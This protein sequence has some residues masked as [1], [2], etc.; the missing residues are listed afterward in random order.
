[1]RSAFAGPLDDD[2][3]DHIIHAVR[4]NP[5]ALLQL[6]GELTPSQL[7]GDSLLPDPLPHFKH[8]EESFLRR[9]RR[10]PSETQ[11]M[12]LLIAADPTLERDLLSRASLDMD[13]GP[14]ALD[15]AETDGLITIGAQV[16]FRHP[17]LRSAIYDGAD[18]AQR[19]DAHHLLATLMD[20][21]LDPDRK[22]WHDGGAAIGPDAAVAA[23]LEHSAER[24]S[25]RGGYAAAAAFLERSVQ[26]TF[27]P[28]IRRGRAL[29]AAEAE[30]TAGAASRAS[31]TLDEVGAEL[32]DP[33]HIAL[34]QRLR[35]VVDLELANG[36]DSAETLL[37]AAQAL[38]PLD[39]RLARD[40]YLE[41]LMAAVYA[42]FLGRRGAVLDA[43][44]KAQAA[45][46]S[47]SSKVMSGDLLLDGFASLII[48][49]PGSAVPT[50][51]RALEQLRDDG[52]L[53]WLGL[54]SIAATELWDDEALHALDTT[55]VRLARDSGALMALP[56]ALQLL[57]IF[58]IHAGRFDTAE[59]CLDEAREIR[60][61]TG[62]PGMI[63]RGNVGRLLLSAWR[64]VP[65]T[66][67]FADVTARDANARG[68][69]IGVDHAHYA[70]ALFELGRCQYDAALVA[71]RAAVAHD[72]IY[73]VPMALPELVEAAARSGNTDEAAA[74]AERLAAMAVA[75]STEWGLGVLAQARALSAEDENAEEL[76]LEALDRLGRCRVV[77]GLGR[78]RLVYGEWLR[79]KRRRADAREQLLAAHQLFSEIG[80][81]GFAERAR[82]ELSAIGGRTPERL[83]E[84]STDV[85]TP[86]EWRIA[87]L[88]ADGA[89]NPEIAAQLFISVRTVE[90]HLHK[91]FRKLEVRSRTE[92]AVDVRLRSE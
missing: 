46:R 42:G 13:I 84:S 35:V 3:R 19:R 69:G 63:D 11:S 62:T 89:S 6:A 26:L 83:A 71:G 12:L 65:E 17:L 8:L 24:A 81:D 10:L 38:E 56:R 31:V 49:G 4:G 36:R 29:A 23:E 16:T 54:G 45:P 48:D 59:A 51:R 75:S 27:E 68:Q 28:E 87:R 44:K 2:V 60:A 76:Y 77:T 85:L 58:E 67:A 39:V 18:P 52:D 66:P 91:I 92:L 9:V 15:A 90:Y 34:A 14:G 5:L 30:L 22:A 50:L 88:V 1:L 55:R 61:A 32:T 79:R 53:A 57:A 74:A 37:A 73:V 40:T 41:A 47:S 78:A 64:G 72:S 21:E 43:A 7:S 25:A 80:A 70:L 33:L 20:P 82:A 86:H